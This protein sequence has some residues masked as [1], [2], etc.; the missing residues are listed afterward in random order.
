MSG[1][2]FAVIFS[3][4]L[5]GLQWF[6]ASATKAME[7]ITFYNFALPVMTMAIYGMGYIARMT[8]A[9]MVRTSPPIFRLRSSVRNVQLN[10]F[11]L[12]MTERT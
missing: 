12:F 11:P 7:N 2:V 1:V 3:S 4:K 8:R 10:G 9:S 5:V 6:S